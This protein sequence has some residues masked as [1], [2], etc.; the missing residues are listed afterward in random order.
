M[1]SLDYVIQGL[2]MSGGG[3]RGGEDTQ[4]KVAERG[5]RERDTAEKRRQQG[6]RVKGEKLERKEVE[7][8][9]EWT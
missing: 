8:M 9:L 4:G 1:I 3:L 6:G 2:E 7:W 5:A